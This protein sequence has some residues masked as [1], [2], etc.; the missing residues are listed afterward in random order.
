[1]LTKNKL[2]LVGVALVAM[3]TSSYAENSNINAAAQAEQ[4]LS[5]FSANSMKAAP[6][7]TA[8]SPSAYGSGWGS[9]YGGF[10]LADRTQTSSSMDGS[11]V[12]GMGFGDPHETVG[13]DVSVGIISTDTGDGGFGDDGNYDLKLSRFISDNMA[14]AIGADNVMPWGNADDNKQSYY[15]VVSNQYHVMGGEGK[16]GLP[17]TVSLGWGTGAY[18]SDSDD[19]NTDDDVADTIGLFSSVALQVNERTSLITDWTGQMFNAGV[20]FVPVK[21]LPIVASLTATD[22]TNRTGNHVPVVA[23]VGYSYT[24]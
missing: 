7:V 10:S 24:F 19:T 11:M 12:V 23:S 22:L 14:V 6:G 5:L 9:V 1:M 2:S 4:V 8:G 3:A 13:L 16:E 17:L 15:G 18:Q 21:S 20:S